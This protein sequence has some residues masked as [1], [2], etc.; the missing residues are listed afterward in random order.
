MNVPFVWFTRQYSASTRLNILPT[1]E[2]TPSASQ[3]VGQG[4][5][6][7]QQQS[8][9]RSSFL[10]SL[11]SGSSSSRAE[12]PRDDPS[13]WTTLVARSIL[14]R[15]HPDYPARGGQSG[16]PV[17][18]V[19][20]STDGTASRSVKVAGFAS[21]VQMVSD[22]QKYDLEGDKLYK[23]LQEGRVAFYG[24]FQVPQELREGYQIL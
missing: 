22:V 9:K 6:R 10:G 14:Y 18:F 19:G 24:A 13:T 17:C 4:I 8:R 20:E 5:F 3:M 16:V 11:S 2:L 1:S 23:R 12:D 15:V 21:F 7:I